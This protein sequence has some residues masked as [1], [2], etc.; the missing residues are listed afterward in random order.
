[1]D[2]RR[3]V[4]RA[5]RART[6]R[7]DAIPVQP[8][9]IVGGIVERIVQHVH[10]LRV[11]RRAADDHAEE[12]EDESVHHAATSRAML[13]SGCGYFPGSHTRPL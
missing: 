7:V 1:M 11:V 5:P 8:P 13:I 10:G 2:T 9:A 3:I 4:A 6:P 12:S